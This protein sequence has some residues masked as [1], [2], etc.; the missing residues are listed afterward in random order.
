MTREDGLE[1]INLAFFIE[2]YHTWVLTEELGRPR[3]KNCYWPTRGMIKHIPIIVSEIK[4]EKYEINTL[5]LSSVY[6]RHTPLPPTWHFKNKEIE[7]RIRDQEKR[8]DEEYYR[9]KY[10]D[11][12]YTLNSSEG[13]T[14][15]AHIIANNLLLAYI[16]KGRLE[17]WKLL[18][19]TFCT[20]GKTFDN[21]NLSQILSTN[22]EH[23]SYLMDPKTSYVHVGYY[24]VVYTELLP[25][26][27]STLETV[28]EDFSAFIRYIAE[29][30]LKTFIV[31]GKYNT[32]RE[33]AFEELSG[34]TIFGTD[35]VW[36]ENNS[37]SDRNSQGQ[38]QNY[39]KILE[40]L[41]R[42]EKNTSPV[43]HM[44]AMVD[45]IKTSVEKISSHISNPTARIFDF[46]I[47]CGALSAPI[48][49][50]LRYIIY[51]QVGSALKKWFD[52]LIKEKGFKVKD[53]PKSSS[54]KHKLKRWGNN[55]MSIEE[56]TRLIGER[57]EKTK[58]G[59]KN[60]E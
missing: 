12:Q 36:E 55:L 52:Y 7:L 56:E 32:E 24:N 46:G 43:P 53:L 5:D 8:P 44:D 17:L 20:D 49:D 38:S 34:T 59:L 48:G 22:P 10:G 50:D 29:V 13:I 39:E 41:M 18:V 28:K 31:E 3:D 47:E 42:I 15:L 4:D 58:S 51:G 19:A 21:D 23:S 40:H 27:I 57:I 11:M 14:S 1:L 6:E 33:K 60:L 16:M 37:P 54:I 9:E 25:L 35:I 26:I 30:N 45:N 2:E